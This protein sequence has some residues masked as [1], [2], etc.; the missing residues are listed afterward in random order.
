MSNIRIYYCYSSL[1]TVPGV[2]SPE[3]ATP[4]KCFQNFL[5]VF[6]SDNVVLLADSTSSEDIQWLQGYIPSSRI[7]QS[8]FGD[9]WQT[10]T[11]LQA[12]SLC[13]QDRLPDDQMIYIT[14]CRFVHLPQARQVLCAGLNIADY[15][16]GYDTPVKYVNQSMVASSGT[17][18]GEY[19]W[20]NSEISNVFCLSDRW[21]F[22][23]TRDTILCILS[24]V[25]SI[26]QDA[27][28]FQSIDT[29]ENF[30]GNS[31]LWRTL[32]NKGRRLISA[33]PAVS[34]LAIVPY[35]APTINWGDVMMKSLN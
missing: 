33:L 7:H 32:F 31:V 26:T 19:V 6:G 16:T 11:F 2:V 8:F 1:Q 35:L 28:I 23:S 13:M 12:I 34:T 17:V 27:S 30:R 25:G 22:K 10:S 9:D 4:R 15:I 21:H 5:S 3:W 24:T 18:G 29:N 20:N 14:N